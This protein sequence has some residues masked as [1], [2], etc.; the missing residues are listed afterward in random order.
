MQIICGRRSV[1]IEIRERIIK[2]VSTPQLKATLRD[3]PLSS[4]YLFSRQELQPV[5]QSLGGS[6][7]WLN[8]PEYIKEK[9]SSKIK[10][11]SSYRQEK[12]TGSSFVNKNSKF[13][14]SNKQNNFQSSQRHHNFKRNFIKKNNADQNDKPK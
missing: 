2:E 10:T 7:T 12:R 1:C 5:I 6:L 11:S 14:T 13:D 3:I 4:E 8:K 9:D